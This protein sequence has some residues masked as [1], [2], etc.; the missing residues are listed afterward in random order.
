MP[1][2]RPP[3]I[4]GGLVLT[5]RADARPHGRA[6]RRRPRRPHRSSPP[7]AATTTQRRRRR[8]W[9]VERA[10]GTRTGPA[11]WTRRPSACS[12]RRPGSTSTTRSSSTT[13]S[14]SPS[15]RP[16]W[17][18]SATSAPTSSPRPAGWPPG[19]SASAGWPSCPSTTS[20]TPSN[21]VADL[22]NPDFDPDGKFTLPCQSGMTGIA[23]NIAD[24]GRELT[25]MADL[26]DPEFKGRIGMLTEMRD[27]VGLTM[28]LDRQGPGNAGA[29]WTTPRR[30]STMIEEA[31]SNGQ[32]R[33]VHRQRLHGRP[34]DGELRRLHRVV[35]R[36]LAARPRQ[37]RPALRHP[38]GGRHALVR[39]D[40]R[41]RPAPR[42][43]PTRPCG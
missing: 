14:P 36:H 1:A 16:T 31:N 30:P 8:R 33:A 29:P 39:H 34:G 7:A 10:R 18:R 41:S 9:R 17:P 25:S 43:S 40:G 27:T 28:L 22:Q 19:S 37:P 12:R 21:L 4:R 20:P 35:G 11:T 42:T 13:T 32:I 15:T 24:T 3:R 2:P 5:R 23:Y 6:R 38:R 26:F